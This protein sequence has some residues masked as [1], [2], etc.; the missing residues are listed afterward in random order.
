M[1]SRSVDCVG[2]EAVNQNLETQSNAIIVNMV[3]VTAVRGGIG[4]IGI[5]TAS[6]ES[7]GTQLGNTTSKRSIHNRRLLHERADFQSWFRGSKTCGTIVDAAC[8]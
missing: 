3:T 1:G 2:Y 8:G 6:G 4:T 7:G 5:F